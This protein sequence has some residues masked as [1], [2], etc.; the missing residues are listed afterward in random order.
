MLALVDLSSRN[1]QD[2]EELKAVFYRN[3]AQNRIGQIQAKPAGENW[4]RIITGKGEYIVR[5]YFSKSKK[6]KLQ[7][8][9]HV[10]KKT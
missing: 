6:K 7:R 2:D 4:W 5:Y 9:R 1:N 10:I 3:I 8:N